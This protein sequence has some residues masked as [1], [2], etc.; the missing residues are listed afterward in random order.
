MGLIQVFQVLNLASEIARAASQL[1]AVAH[2]TIQA[3]LYVEPSFRSSCSC[4]LRVVLRPGPAE[5]GES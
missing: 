2:A 5:Y 3:S 4:L 1:A